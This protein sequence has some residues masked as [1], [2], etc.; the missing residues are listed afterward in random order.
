MA[1]VRLER[2]GRLAA[3]HSELTEYRGHAAEGVVSVLVK[4]ITR[5]GDAARARATVL[6]EFEALTRARACVGPDL[7]DSLPRPWLVLPELQALVVGKLPGVPLGQIL[8]RHANPVTGSF[9]GRRAVEAVAQAGRWLQRFHAATAQAVRPFDGR[10]YAA[11]CRDRL[12]RCLAVGM[13]GDTEMV[14]W[15][16]ASRASEAA[17]G[18]EEHTAAR[19]GD[20]LPQ[21]VLVHQGRVA[22]ADLENFADCDAVLV[23]VGTMSAFLRLMASVPLYSRRTLLAARTRFLDAYGEQGNSVLLMLHELL[24]SITVIAQLRPRA[25]GILQA[26]RVAWLS[27]AVRHLA[28]QIEAAHLSVGR[29]PLHAGPRVPQP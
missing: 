4:R 24:Q 29:P 7:A 2:V 6:R 3:R 12:D 14:T 20:F 26:R 1:G 11:T 8:R 23:D 13:D 16:I 15:R 21:N 19:H 18:L 27:A 10:A 25:T 22:V 9:Q 28:F 5:G 17:T